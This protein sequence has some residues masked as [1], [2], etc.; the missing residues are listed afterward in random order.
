MEE[1]PRTGLQIAPELAECGFRRGSQFGCDPGLLCCSRRYQFRRHAGDFRPQL[2]RCKSRQQRRRARGSALCRQRP[3]R[4]TAQSSRGR[5]LHYCGWF[6]GSFYRQAGVPF[7][8]GRIGISG[9]STRRHLC[10][11]ARPTNKRPDADRDAGGGLCCIHGKQQHQG[12]HTD[13]KN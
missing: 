13:L 4:R 8:T 12:L 1:L 9:L 5:A 3:G 6:I 2:H 11:R 10:R 7:C